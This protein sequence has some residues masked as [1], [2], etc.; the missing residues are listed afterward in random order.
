VETASR[1]FYAEG[2]HAVG[3]D[4][5]VA[6]S[7]VTK[8]TFYRHFATK[9]HLVVAHVQWQDQLIRDAVT[10]AATDLPVGDMLA[11]FFAGLAGQICGPGF[12]GCPF[13]NAAAEYPDAN[14]PVRQAVTAH[15]QWLQ[16]TF[17]DLLRATGHPAPL[18]TAAAL[19]L[20]RDGAMV[21]G[22]LDN[23]DEVRATLHD[24]VRTLVGAGPAAAS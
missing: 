18:P 16:G 13:I 20:L 17:A 11:A 2:I 7:E 3:V 4:R 14:H 8:A 24:A 19:V 23:P 9:D 5:L 10:A 22:Y 21:G 1:I 15:R 6:E 12:R